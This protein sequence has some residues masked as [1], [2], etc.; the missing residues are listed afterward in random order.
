MN[1][2]E[3]KQKKTQIK[4]FV[5]NL[6]EDFNQK[7]SYSDIHYIFIFLSEEFKNRI[8]PKEQFIEQMFNNFKSPQ[9]LTNSYKCD[10]NQPNRLF[11]YLKDE[12]LALNKIFYE[13]RD[14]SNPIFSVLSN[15]FLTS[16]K[17]TNEFGHIIYYIKNQQENLLTS[18]IIGD[19]TYQIIGLIFIYKEKL[20]DIWLVNIV[21][22]YFY[23]LSKKKWVISLNDLTKPKYSD[24]VIVYGMNENTQKNYIYYDKIICDSKSFKIIQDNYLH[25]ILW[26]IKNDCN[27]IDSCKNLMTIFDLTNNFNQITKMKKYESLSKEE[28]QKLN[29]YYHKYSNETTDKHN[30]K[31]K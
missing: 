8:E 6:K 12:N 10:E 16:Q 4:E 27:N 9:K 19:K 25:E 15:V 3:I 14:N 29:Y 26:L 31:N 13:T 22:K 17:E 11:P 24:I 20:S 7:W 23:S 18:K 2:Y 1:Y 21:N 30:K 5:S 28:C